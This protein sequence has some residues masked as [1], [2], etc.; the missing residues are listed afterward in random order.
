MCF[1][2]VGGTHDGE[3][4]C[5]VK[6]IPGETREQVLMF[7]EHLMSNTDS[8]PAVCEE[9]DPNK[10]YGGVVIFEKDSDF[11]DFDKEAVRRQLEGDDGPGD[12]NFSIEHEAKE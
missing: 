8:P 12:T 9:F 1:I 4:N 3:I 5:K 11:T 7:C 2:A 6:E 10:D